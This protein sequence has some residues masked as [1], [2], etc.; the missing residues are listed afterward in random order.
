MR[1][2]NVLLTALVALR[3]A[4]SATDW[5]RVGRTPQHSDSIPAW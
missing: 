4:A 2:A 5:P 3:Q 1:R